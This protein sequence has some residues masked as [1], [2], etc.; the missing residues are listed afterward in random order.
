MLRVRTVGV[1]VLVLLGSAQPELS[2]EEPP[3]SSISIFLGQQDPRRRFWAR[4]EL[5]NSP[6][7]FLELRN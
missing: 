3:Q 1:V 7:G 2:E 4:L 5:K 6:D